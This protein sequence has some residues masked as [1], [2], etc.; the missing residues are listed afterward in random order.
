MAR[1]TEIQ[2]NA[3]SGPVRVFIDGA[4]CVQIRAR[5]FSAMNLFVGQEVTCNE[6][7][8]LEK[9][10]WKHAYGEDA[11]E[12]EKL[13]LQRVIDLINWADPRA[14]A[15][16]VGFGAQSTEF[17]PE[18]EVTG[19]NGGVVQ[20]IGSAPI[21]SLMRNAILIGMFGL[22]CTIKSPRNG[23]F[24]YA[25]IRIAVMSHRTSLFE[26]QPSATF[27]FQKQLKKSR[28]SGALSLISPRALTN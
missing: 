16:A 26:A 12:R 1:I 13:R 21:K 28:R 18:H 2:H 17:I 7:K 5:T 9:H 14:E 3:E 22:P 15:I 24:C 4:F 11:W 10:F 27:C 25:Q 20:S 19:Q 6:L 23:L 8:E